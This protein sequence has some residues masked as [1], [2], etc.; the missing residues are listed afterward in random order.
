[1]TFQAT[2]NRKLWVVFFLLTGAT[3]LGWYGV[4]FLN[5][6]PIR[7]EDD[8]LM[9]PG[10]KLLFS[11]VMGVVV[12]SWTVSWGVLLRQLLGGTAFTLEADGIHGTVIAQMRFALILVMPV[13]RIP[14][15]AIRRVEVEEGMTVLHLDTALV[16]APLGRRLLAR[17]YHLLHGFTKET[18]EEIRAA[19]ARFGVTPSHTDTREDAL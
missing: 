5:T 7:M 13:R 18:P 16:E 3:A 6:H 15:G 11:L 12:L 4:W 14:Y 17:E 9:D 19:L 2:C 1:M 8:A 10:T